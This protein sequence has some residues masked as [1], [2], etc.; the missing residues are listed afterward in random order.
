MAGTVNKHIRIDEEI[1]E[2]LEAACGAP[3]E[4][5]TDLAEI[6]PRRPRRAGLCCADSD[7]PL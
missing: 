6:N 5:A 1:W 3:L 2:R 4:L 7:R